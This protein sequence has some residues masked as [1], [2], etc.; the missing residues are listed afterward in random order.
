MADPV[1]PSDVTACLAVA[2]RPPVAVCLTDA[3]PPGVPA[4]TGRVPAGC[5]FWQEAAGGPFATSPADHDL[6][7]IGTFTHN[8]DATDAHESR[9]NRRTT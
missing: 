8:M 4:F 1:R 3:V 6:C 2:A 5:A 9:L 7:G